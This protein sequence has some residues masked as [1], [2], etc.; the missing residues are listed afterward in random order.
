MQRWQRNASETKISDDKAIA[1]FDAF[2]ATTD[3]PSFVNIREEDIPGEDVKYLFADYIDFLLA[4][5]MF[6]R[7]SKNSNRPIDFGTVRDYFRKIKILLSVAFPEHEFLKEKEPQWWLDTLDTFKKCHTRESN[8]GTLCSEPI[9]N[10]I[11]LLYARART[12]TRLT[13][14]SVANDANYE[15]LYI[16]RKCF[17]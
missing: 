11:L 4:N 13:L 8:N 6:D 17:R 7:R 3:L 10:T 9:D 5:P 2:L 12:A 14:S 16:M 1:P 15:K